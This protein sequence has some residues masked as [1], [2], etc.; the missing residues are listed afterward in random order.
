MLGTADLRLV[1]LLLSHSIASYL[2]PQAIAYHQALPSPSEPQTTRFSNTLESILGLMVVV[3]P[4][5]DKVSEAG[6][7]SLQR[8]RPALPATFITHTLLFAHLPPVLLS[9]ILLAYT[10]TTPPS[11][12]AILRA[13]FLKVLATLSPTQCIAAFGA[14]LKLR[15]RVKRSAPGRDQQGWHR[16]WPGYVYDVS[17]GMMSSQVRR[18]GGVKAVMENVFGEAANLSDQSGT[19]CEICLFIS[20]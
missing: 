2:L 3:Q 1:R 10:P 16:N 12:H 20:N 8:Q 9:I 5:D 6:P 4:P 11:I 14:T 17:G 13:S 7:S 19:S 18:P 15:A